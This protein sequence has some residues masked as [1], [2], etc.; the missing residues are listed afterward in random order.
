MT[1]IVVRHPEDRFDLE[2]RRRLAE[3]LTDAV[4][5]PEVGAFVEAARAGFQV[6]FAP[7]PTDHL[8]I[9]GRLLSDEPRD[10]V[11]VDI[12]VM[13]GHWPPDVR[14]DVVRRVLA[15]MAE[16]VGLDAPAPD[17]WVNLRPVADGSWGA[18]GDVLTM[19][20]LLGFGLFTDEREAA[21]RADL[22]ARRD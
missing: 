5:V 7:V 22:A 1:V 15:A 21:I 17:W 13:D 2:Q 9:G 19:E 18:F 3:G 10:V 12:A 11:L 8:A 16:A 4:L 14:A 20:T 6:H